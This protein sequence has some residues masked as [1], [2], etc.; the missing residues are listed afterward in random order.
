MAYRIYFKSGQRLFSFVS[1]VDKKGATIGMNILL[2]LAL[3]FMLALH[4]ND[5]VCAKEEVK[6]SCKDE[7]NQNVDW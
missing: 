2:N 3:T 4:F 6:V 5:F 1:E 7:N